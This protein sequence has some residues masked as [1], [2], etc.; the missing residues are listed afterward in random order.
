MIRRCTD[1]TV[2][3]RRIGKNIS[4]H[5]G[6]PKG[7]PSFYMMILW[8]GRRGR[9]PRRPAHRK[10]VGFP[11]AA[12]IGGPSGRPAPT[13]SKIPRFRSS[14]ESGD[15]FAQNVGNG[16]RA[17]PQYEPG[18]PPHLRR[19]GTSHRPPLSLR[20]RRPWQS[21]TPAA[22]RA[23]RSLRDR[24]DADCQKVNCPKGKRGHPGVRRA[25]PSS[26]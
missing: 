9:R 11:D 16:L 14:S 13:R 26:Q 17:V 1:L 3:A 4:K 22:Q 5:L 23:A 20:G 2:S 12:G 6:R 18:Q 21:V 10:A 19:N 15:F 24:R 8:D 25:L 7:R